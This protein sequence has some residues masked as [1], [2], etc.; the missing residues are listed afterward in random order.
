MIILIITI[1]AIIIAIFLT[2]R[3]WRALASYES[4][5]PDSGMTPK[6]SIIV[7]AK[8]Y[9]EKLSQ[10]L[11]LLFEQDYP[12]FEV[13]L[14]CDASAE[15]T[16]IISKGLEENHRLHI[17]FIP[18]GSHNVSRRKLAETI[19]IKAATGEIVVITSTMTLP[20]SNKW[21]RAMAAPFAD[22]EVALSMGHV[23]PDTQ[24]LKG[25]SRYFKTFSYTLSAIQW[26][27]YAVMGRPYRA[28]GFNLAFRRHI[29]FDNKGYSSTNHLTDGDDD[30]FLTE[31]A[32]RGTCIPVINPDAMLRWSTGDDTSRLMRQEKDRRLFTAKFL[33]KAPFFN[34]ALNSWM[35]WISLLAGICALISAIPTAFPQLVQYLNSASATVPSFWSNACAFLLSN[36]L[37]AYSNSIA[38]MASMILLIIGLP[39]FYIYEF[40]LFKLDSDKLNSESLKR[41]KF[42]TFLP[43]LLW[44][45]ISN[46][47][48]RLHHAA[49][50]ASHLTTSHF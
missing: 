20:L 28:E 29:F 24:S 40:Y 13:I 33:P 25:A 36:P 16:A 17:T 7:I 48:F 34:G 10:Y 21:L 39:A 32:R 23:Q 8:G 45:P 11:D 41:S 9:E 26:F 44:R 43:F 35:Q 27:G 4:P 19:G 37:T 6:L 3:P 50:P 22:S 15:Q 12:D 5:L 14:V 46:A 18:Q 30:I 47:I 2:L 1:V 38:A 31:L 42:Y 49:P